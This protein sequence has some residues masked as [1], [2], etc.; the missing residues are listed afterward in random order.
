MKVSFYNRDLEIVATGKVFPGRLPAEVATDLQGV[1]VWMK[2]AM[3]LRDLAALPH[4]APDD[5]SAGL[6]SLRLPLGY[7][8]R[9][10]VEHDEITVMGVLAPVR[11]A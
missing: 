4:F 2:H 3:S 6:A 8:L 9:Y 7:T 5:S 1:V 11:V 10:G